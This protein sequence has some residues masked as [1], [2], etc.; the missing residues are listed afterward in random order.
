M[1]ARE[2][3]QKRRGT[4]SYLVTGYEADSPNKVATIRRNNKLVE[5]GE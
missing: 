5:K 3:K 1:R 2:L 4:N